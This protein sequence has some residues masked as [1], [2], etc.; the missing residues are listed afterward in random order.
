MSNIDVVLSE[1]QCLK[2]FVK[3]N[4]MQLTNDQIWA[5]LHVHYRADYG[6]AITLLDIARIFPASNALLERCFSSMQLIKTDWRNRLDADTVECLLCIKREAPKPGLPDAKDL[7]AK[8]ADR[9]FVT[10]RRPRAHAIGPQKKI[11]KILS[12]T[13]SVSQ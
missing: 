1:W 8:A 9:F 4:M 11:A 6:N 2:H 10:P 13:D 5:A 3:S 12:D 7:I